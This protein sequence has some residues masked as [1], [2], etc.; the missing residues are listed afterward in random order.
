MPHSVGAQRD[1]LGR[2]RRSPGAT[3]DPGVGGG[4]FSPG[5]PSSPGGR[6][7]GSLGRGFDESLL[8][9]IGASNRRRARQIGGG[10]ARRVQTGFRNR[11]VPSAALFDAAGIAG[12]AESDALTQLQT[13]IDVASLGAKQQGAIAGAGLDVN[14]FNIMRRRQDAIKAARAN[15][16]TTVSTP[17]G[18][19]SF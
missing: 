8:A 11:T 12:R 16:Q 7:Q 4:L 14:L 10:V 15:R 3:S 1:L 19:I 17:F 5:V 2:R 13:P 6:F 9:R 18:G